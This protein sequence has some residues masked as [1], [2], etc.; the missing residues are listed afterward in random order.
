VQYDERPIFVFSLWVEDSSC[1]D[2]SRE[3]VSLIPIT[4]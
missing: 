4:Y 1:E 3:G 2:S